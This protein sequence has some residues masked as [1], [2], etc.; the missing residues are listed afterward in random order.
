MLLS[1][2]FIKNYP[3][4]TNLCICSTFQ[5]SAFDFAVQAVF[6]EKV[7]TSLQLSNSKQQNTTICLLKL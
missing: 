1:E 4:Y 2:T 6:L 7:L 5:C 3:I